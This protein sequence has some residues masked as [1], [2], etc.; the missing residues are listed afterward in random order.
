MTKP[1]FRRFVTNIGILTTWFERGAAYVSKAYM[2]ALSPPHKVF[3]YARG[4]EEYGKGDANWDLPCVTWAPRLEGMLYDSGTAMSMTHFWKWLRDNAIDVVIMN[5]Q[6]YAVNVYVKRIVDLGYVVGAYVDYYTKKTVPCFDAYDFLLCNTKRHYSVFRNHRKCLFIQWGTDVN[7]FKPSLFYPDRTSLDAVVFF[8][9]T[10]W[11]NL[12]KGADLLVKA[13]QKV[14]GKVKLLIHSQTPVEEYGD[15]AE[16]IRKDRRIE[17]IEKT[18]P[19]P[20]LYHMGD[21]FVYP[22]K[23]EGIGL[24]VPEALACGLPVITTDNAPMNEFVEDGY[25]GFLVRVAVTRQR[26][27]KYYWPQTYVDIDDLAA[28]MQFYADHPEIIAQHQR[29]ARKSAEEKFDWVK[30]SRH[31]ASVINEMAGP[32]SVRKPSVIER[33]RWYGQEVFLICQKNFFI[34]A[35]RILPH[36]VAHFLNAPFRWLIRR[37][38]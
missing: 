28:K 1:N 11:G 31:F 19:A 26:E 35:K 13:F 21:V 5:E 17:F 3:I 33:L 30:N 12:R 15:T 24:C 32:K 18:V 6:R 20:G 27:D 10:G 25:N 34:T 4:G 9:S 29:N 36:S 23:L 16:L 2:K 37:R 7:L 14:S 8:H 22:S 38:L